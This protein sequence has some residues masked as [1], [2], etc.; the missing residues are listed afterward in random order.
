MEGQHEP[1]LGADS[2]TGSLGASFAHVAPPSLRRSMEAAVSLPRGRSEGVE[3]TA[4][5]PAA[6][7]AD[8]QHARVFADGSPG[9]GEDNR[10][11]KQLWRVARHRVGGWM[12][13]AGRGAP[14]SGGMALSRLC[15][16]DLWAL[17]PVLPAAR[18]SCIAQR[19]GTCCLGTGADSN[20]AAGA[21]ACGRPRPLCGQRPV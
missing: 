19:C 11:G 2:G 18:I 5:P 21:A 12:G 1:L 14:P 10:D 13:G 3:G 9:G 7:A 4:S 20:G 16:S 15:S 17:S 6:A 8:G